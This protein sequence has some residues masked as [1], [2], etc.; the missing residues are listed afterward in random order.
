MY[1]FAE[2]VTDAQVQ[3][4]QSR[5]KAKIEE[6][7]R[8]ILGLNKAVSNSDDVEKEDNNWADIQANVQEAMD[9]DERSVTKEASTA[10]EKGEETEE[11][12]Q[13]EEVSS[14]T[15]E[16]VS[17]GQKDTHSEDDPKQDVEMSHEDS[18]GQEDSTEASPG[19][20]KELQEQQEDEEPL[21]DEPTITFDGRPKKA[22]WTDENTS[23]ST[24]PTTL[25]PAHKSR[26]PSV[27]A[28]SQETHADSQFLDLID[29]EKESTKPPEA[30]DILA[31][32]LTIRN[33]INNKYVLR[34]ENLGPTDNWSVEYSLEE[35]PQPDRAWS[36]YQACQLRR[37]KRLDDEQDGEQN[38][39]VNYYVERMRELSNKGKAWR[40]QQDQQD[41]GSQKIVVGQPLS[42]EYL[43]THTSTTKTSL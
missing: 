33:K 20:G 40:K 11:G 36:L 6:F 37:K 19:S 5:N 22:E 39:A 41:E 30:S 35:V 18:S 3:S 16:G 2:P 17:T 38:A 15:L 14:Y 10:V 28:Q 1:V 4:L 13:E 8:K 42:P 25:G 27:I 34:P 26:V 9:K 43:Q 24:G 29:R 21:A 32:T 12:G 23:E 31:M 7:E